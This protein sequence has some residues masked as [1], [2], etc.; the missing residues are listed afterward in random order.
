MKE[1]DT[2][3]VKTYPLYIL[4]VRTPTYPKKLSIAS[5]LVL[6]V[7]VDLKIHRLGKIIRI[8]QYYHSVL[9]IYSVLVGQIVEGS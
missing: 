7:Y 5:R 3:G 9:V 8:V 1:C 4:G 2:L 6:T